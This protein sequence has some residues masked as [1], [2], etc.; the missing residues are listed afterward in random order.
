M[1]ARGAQGLGEDR[2]RLRRR[3]GRPF[4]LYAGEVGVQPGQCFLLL[5]IGE[6]RGLQ[7][8]NAD[9]LPVG[10]GPAEQASSATFCS[11]D[12]SLAR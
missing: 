7:G 5:G 3:Y 2:F 12:N 9:R 11:D 4:G 1:G 6:Q 8:A 10:D